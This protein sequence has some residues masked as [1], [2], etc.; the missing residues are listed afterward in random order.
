MCEMPL[1]AC[2]LRRL[3]ECPRLGTG[4]CEARRA[5][6][7]WREAWLR[8]RAFCGEADTLELQGE[9][10]EGGEREETGFGEAL[11]RWLS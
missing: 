10:E 8:P 9:R 4:R 11:L 7:T 3:S 2:S 5:C 6:S 1:G